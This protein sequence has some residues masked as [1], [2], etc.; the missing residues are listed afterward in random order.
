MS[1]L[2]S[3]QPPTPHQPLIHTKMKTVKIRRAHSAQYGLRLPLT[4]TGLMNFSIG[5][6]TSL[7]L[8]FSLPRT[9]SR[10]RASDIEF[11]RDA[12]HAMS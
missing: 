6:L 3:R 10:A 1:R 12:Q 9:P 11:A 5:K 7:F 2:R 4:S 8:Y